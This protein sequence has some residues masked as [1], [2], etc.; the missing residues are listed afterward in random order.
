MLKEVTKSLDK[1]FIISNQPLFKEYTNKEKAFISNRAKVVEYSKGDTIYSQG[2]KAKFLYV[3]MAGRVVLY[4]SQKCQKKEKLVDMLKKGD[5]FGIVSILTQ[6]SH[7]VSAKAANDS[8]IIIIHEN[9]LKEILKRIPRLAITFSKSLSRRVHE[10]D[11]GKRKIFESKIISIYDVSLDLDSAANYGQMLAENIAVQSGKKVI[12]LWVNDKAKKKA[13]K[14]RTG[15]IF[16]NVPDE[17]MSELSNYTAEYHFILLLFQKELKNMEIKMLKQADSHH[18]IA[19]PIDEDIEKV[20]NVL[21]Y[22]G[23]YNK[24]DVRLILKEEKYINSLKTEEIKKDLKLNLLG[25]LPD[26]RENYVRAVRRIS[27]EA[28]GVS[29]GLALGAGGALGLAEIGILD[30]FEK[31]KIPIDIIAGTSIGSIIGAFWALGF[32]AREIE[33]IIGGYTKNVSAVALIDPVVPKYGLIGG[34]NIR[35]FLQSH[36]KDRTFYDLKKPLRIVACDIDNREEFVISSGKLV[37]AI[38]A[39]IAIPGIFTPITWADGK[40]LVDGGVVSPVPIN[41]LAKE[42]I[43]TII[44]V[45]AMPS[46]EDNTNLAGAR[47]TIFDVIVNSFY[48]MEYRIGKFASEEADIYMHPILKGASWHEFFRVKEFVKCGRQEAKKILPEIKKL[49]KPSI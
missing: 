9:D 1:F 28:S 48:S 5:Y 2:E 3:V 41:I 25:T 6:K 21:N 43:K 24:N 12:L 14:I 44:A 23:E 17:G 4:Q 42:G 29:V 19:R 15:E 26:T 35:N 31:E 37:D 40:Y 27:R 13:S 34:K 11:I 47:R 8:K 33:E 32:K 10:T 30:V 36:I 16:F 39:S 38:M 20:K 7:T 49:I 45:N 18:L 22:I 46:P